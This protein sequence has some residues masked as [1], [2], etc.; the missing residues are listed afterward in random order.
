L[1]GPKITAVRLDRASAPS[2]GEVFALSGFHIETKID[3]IIPKKTGIFPEGEL[4]FPAS[5]LRGNL[6]D[7]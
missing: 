7:E 3:G 6:F 4:I 1:A 5:V 2:I